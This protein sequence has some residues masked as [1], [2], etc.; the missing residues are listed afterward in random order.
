MPPTLPLTTYEVTD[1]GRAKCLHV[2]VGSLKQK[3]HEPQPMSVFQIYVSVRDWSILNPLE[4]PSFQ[5]VGKM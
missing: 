4:K 5:G 3:K 2:L 1:S